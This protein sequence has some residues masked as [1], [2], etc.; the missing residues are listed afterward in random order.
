MFAGQ[1]K[2]RLLGVIEA[3]QRPAI[4]VV[5]AITRRTEPPLVMG[6]L[7]AGNARAR[8]ILEGL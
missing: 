5:A 6:V 3:P 7:V 2:A 4:R 8:R 1:G